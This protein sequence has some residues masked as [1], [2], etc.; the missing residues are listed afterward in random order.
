MGYIYIH[1][2]TLEK[3]KIVRYTDKDKFTGSVMLSGP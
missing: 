1:T 2:H 3:Q